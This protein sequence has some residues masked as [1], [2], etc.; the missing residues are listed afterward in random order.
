M[1]GDIG[2]DY[3]HSKC[4]LI[5][6]ANP[7]HN[8][9]AAERDINIARSKGAK[10]ICIDPRPPE[11]MD[12]F[13]LGLPPADLWL[14]IRPGTDAA[15]ALAMI[16]VVIEEGLYNKNF[17]HNWCIGFEDLK[18]HVES[19]TLEKVEEI[20]W[21][22]KEQIIAAARLFAKNR[23]SCLHSRLG[24]GSQH[25]NATQTMRAISIFLALAGDIDI[26]GGNLISGD[27]GGFK[28]P[29]MITQILRPPA[30]VDQKRIGAKKFPFL[31]GP[32]EIAH[33]VMPQAHTPSA[34]RAILRGEIKA[35]YIPGSNIVLM[36]GD[37]HQTWTA[38]R[39]LDFL[40][41]SDFFM[42]PTA[43][44]AD[45][46]LPAAHWLEMGIPMRAYQ[47]MGP[48]RYNHILASRKV[49]EPRG[50]CW[51]DR[52]MILEL[53]KR[54]G[55]RVPWQNVEDFHNWQMEE[56][57]VSFEE[58]QKKPHQMISFPISYKKYK[59]GGFRTPSRKVELRSSILE[60]MGYD[61]LPPYIEPP[62]SPLSTPELFQE[63]PLIMITH[64]NIIYM[65]SEFRQLSSFRQAEPH[66]FIEINP[67]TASEKGIQ[68]GDWIWVQRP[69]F[70]G[71]VNGKA[72]YVSELDPRIISVHVGWW[73]PEQ[74]APEHGAFEAN[75]NALI[76]TGPPYDPINGNH[77]ARALL[78]KIGKNI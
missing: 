62:Q 72:R 67:Q 65:H 66:P 11:R 6:G 31:A 64:R 69:G 54:M 23:P 5:W 61:P 37:S 29:E 13:K 43:E 52:K 39:R 47:V 42:T 12:L 74:P 14:R 9:P 71:K 34:I 50:E 46:V 30:E 60:K 16:R 8:R 38:L 75:I 48:R 10:V 35:F 49:L 28:T 2:P 32:Q 56:V 59:E 15:L 36:E 77:Q 68:D 20:T 41:V 57:G 55:I 19:F 45:L 1:T 51:D 24:S 4:I 33:Y 18:E 21:I 7:R 17:I 53:A 3:Q 73:F 58:I 26:P 44:V 78:C 25:I 27:L 22:P 63:Y 76:S 40:V 70:Q